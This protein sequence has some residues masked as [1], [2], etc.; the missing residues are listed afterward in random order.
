MKKVVGFWQFWKPRVYFFRGRFWQ[1]ALRFQTKQK[2]VIR[3]PLFPAFV[4]SVTGRNFV[5]KIE[6]NL[7]F[8][9]KGG[10]SK[11]P[12]PRKSLFFFVVIFDGLFLFFKQSWK[13]QIRCFGLFLENEKNEVYWKG[14]RF[15]SAFRPRC[16]FK[17]WSFFVICSAFPN[18]A[19]K[20]SSADFPIFSHWGIIWWN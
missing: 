12:P 2:I 4:T 11:N 15:Y 13:N 14:G 18:K 8:Y 19:K 9:R 16:L 3:W 6:P 1:F 10:G 20:M 5:L 7:E 17:M